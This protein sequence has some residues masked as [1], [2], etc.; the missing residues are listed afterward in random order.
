MQLLQFMSPLT[1]KLETGYVL[2]ILW[3]WYGCI[4]A[5]QQQLKQLIGSDTNESELKK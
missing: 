5:T 2:N 4:S 3:T 1:D